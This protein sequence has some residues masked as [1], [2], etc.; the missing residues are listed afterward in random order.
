MNYLD[1][2]CD[3]IAVCE[4][5]NMS[6]KDN[7]CQLSLEQG[8][9]IN[10]W[11]QAYAIW[12]PDE[13]RGEDAYNYFD[14]VYKYF[15]QELENN[16][17]EISL[18]RNYEEIEEALNQS[19]RVAILA[20]EGSAALGGKLDRI[21]ELKDKGV[22]MMTLTWNGKTEVGDGC[23]LENAGGLTGF[24]KAVIKEMN[25][26]NIIIDVSHL[27]P[28]GV[29]D[30]I[31]NTTKPFIATHSNS[32]EVLNHPRNLSDEYFKE[33][34]NRGGVVGINFYPMFVNGTD[35]AFIK[36]LFSHITHFIEL[37]GENNI[38]LGSDFDGASMPEDLQ[39]ISDITRLY[40]DM[41]CEYGDEITNKIF[42]NNGRDFYKKNL[43]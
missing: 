29:K 25:K 37:G 6:I 10:K 9:A 43:V 19:K 39:N 22:S 14:R 15:L 7:E 38:C 34:I 35:S 27:S 23:M 31:Q 11:I 1:L 33:I 24:G 41:K 5:R 21:K 16:K 18:C 42:F 17:S 2:H 36:E 32:Y 4:E 3:T 13:L 20:I 26:Y 30:V 28:K 12:I 8:K 40:E